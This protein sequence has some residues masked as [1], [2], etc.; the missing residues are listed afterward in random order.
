[1]AV[2]LNIEMPE[3]CDLCLFGYLSN[4]HQTAACYLMSDTQ[5]FDDF[6]TKYKTR[7][8]VNCPLEEHKP[9]LGRWEERYRSKFDGTRYWFRAC[10]ECDFERDDCNPEKDTM[11]CPNCGAKMEK[12][13]REKEK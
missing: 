2:I 11:Y 12:E 4:L 5:M 13:E 10:S 7:R 6:S 9:K 3:C 1:M 8:S